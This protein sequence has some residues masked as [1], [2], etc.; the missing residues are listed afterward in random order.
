MNIDDKGHEV[1][2][3]PNSTRKRHVR[4]CPTGISRFRASAAASP[5]MK[6]AY[7]LTIGSDIRAVAS[8]FGLMP[9][10]ARFASESIKT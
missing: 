3:M 10:I 6:I 1:G 4:A 5:A 9:Y 2:A 8:D 7:E